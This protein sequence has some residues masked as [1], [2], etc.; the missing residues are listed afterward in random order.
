MMAS[1]GRVESN[2][3][4][5][6]GVAKVGSEVGASACRGNGGDGKRLLMALV[7]EVNCNEMVDKFRLSALVGCRAGRMPH[8]GRWGYGDTIDGSKSPDSKSPNSSLI[9]A[10]PGTWEALHNNGAED[11]NSNG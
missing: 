8:T 1:Q 5:L 2:Q 7:N 9:R 6:A 10:G 3:G 11:A 4:V